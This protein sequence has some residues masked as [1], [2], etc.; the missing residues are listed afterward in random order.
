MS[1][2]HVHP[3]FASILASVAGP[4]RCDAYKFPHRKGGGLC[5]DEVEEERLAEF[6]DQYLDDPRHGQAESINVDNN[7]SR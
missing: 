2:S 5:C 3:I 7:R 1:N 4:C 6:N